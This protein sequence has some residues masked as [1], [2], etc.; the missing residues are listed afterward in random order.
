MKILI[1]G[2]MFP[3]I[4][5]GTS[6]HTYNLAK[7]LEKQNHSVKIVT[8]E[9][10]V[11]AE[12]D[13][14]LDVLR[15]SAIRLRIK[16]YFKHLSFVSHN[17]INYASVF[18]QCRLF[19]PDVIFLVNHYLD[20]AFIAIFISVCFRLPL[21]V[22]I[23]TQLQSSNPSRHKILNFL[24][25]LICGRLILPFC[26]VICCWDSEILR[27][28][29][30]TYRRDSLIKKCQ[31]VPYG[32]NGDSQKFLD[33]HHDYEQSEL[34][35]GVGAVSEQRNF[36]H[37]VWCLAS[38]R[39]EF[40][41]LRAEVIGHVYLDEPITLAKDLGVFDYI[42]FVG[43][44]PH[45]KVM[46]RLNNAFLYWGIGSAQYAG[47][48]T[49]VLEAML[50]GIPVVSR[51]PEDLLGD[52]PLRDLVDLVLSDGVDVEAT[53]RKVKQLINST[54]ERKRIGGQG[55]ES[56]RKRMSWEMVGRKYLDCFSKA[57]SENNR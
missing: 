24:D 55:R 17:P 21:V 54:D 30:E 57:I 12:V 31:V 44:E 19:K 13:N 1:I 47:L 9:Y 52:P 3:P 40:P 36:V 39:K 6:F 45:D 20:I 51:V 4:Q 53:C 43:E 15:L 27:Y 32:V 48:G 56:V 50:K 28:V 37:L 16:S 34:I 10:G 22:S 46:E 33:Y 7:E 38:L 11:D 42:D 14:E 8:S 25:R 26:K 49:A 23:G 5:T 2:S 41:N 29:Q 18:K 35:I